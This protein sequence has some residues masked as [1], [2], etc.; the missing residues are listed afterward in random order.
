MRLG[1]SR[2]PACW[3]PSIRLMGAVPERVCGGH[4]FSQPAFAAQGEGTESVWGK[5]SC[6]Q[7]DVVRVHFCPLPARTGCSDDNGR[8]SASSLGALARDTPE[9]SLALGQESPQG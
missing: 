4:L 7:R 1:H 5:L 9:P 8:L 6:D 3:G 2:G